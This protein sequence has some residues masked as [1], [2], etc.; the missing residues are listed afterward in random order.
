L[1]NTKNIR[2]TK[3]HQ[4]QRG[5]TKFFLLHNHQPVTNPQSTSQDLIEGAR[6]DLILQWIVAYIVTET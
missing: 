3:K 6:P 4:L 5:W 2:H 1:K